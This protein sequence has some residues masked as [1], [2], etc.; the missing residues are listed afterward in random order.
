MNST[1]YMTQAEAAE[2]LRLS[3]RTLERLRVIGTGPRFAK[4]G[5]RV[6]YRRGDV[7][8]WVDGHSFVSTREALQASG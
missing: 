5:R 8:A 2:L 4:A 1:S 7:E 3:P 6:L